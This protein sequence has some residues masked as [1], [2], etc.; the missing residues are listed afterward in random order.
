MAMSQKIKDMSGELKAQKEALSGYLQDYQKLTG[1]NEIEDANGV[2]N[3]ILY[4][5]RL[6]KP[7]PNL[8]GN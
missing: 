8:G 4:T 6:I 7:T 1:A 5:A 3:E 2:L